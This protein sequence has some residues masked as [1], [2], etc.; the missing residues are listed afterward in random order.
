MQRQ[1]DCDPARTPIEPTTGR[2]LEPM[3]QPGYYPGYR[4][5]SQQKFWDEA[6]REVVRRR[7]LDVPPIR[8]FT[9]EA[10]RTMGAVLDRVLPQDDRDDEHRIPLLN[11]IDEKLHANRISGYRFADM[12]PYQESHRLGLQAIDAIA[13]YLHL[14]PFV[15]LDV[16]EQEEVLKT[17]HDGEPPAGHEVWERMSVH[18]YWSQL[19]HDAAEAYYSHPYAWDEIGFGGPAYPRAYFRLN[20][21]EP[22]PWEVEEQRYSWAP[23]PQSISAEYTP[24]ERSHP[25]SPGLTT[26]AGGTH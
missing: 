25:E 15:A 17:I 11:M 19:L 18:R 9:P 26:G 7:V 14:K 3:A 6:T 2:P 12:P 4:T 13:R 22:E 21:G 24:I 23:P 1:H 10:A 20:R 16:R 8:F 5:L